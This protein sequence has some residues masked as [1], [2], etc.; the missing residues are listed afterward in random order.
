MAGYDE[1]LGQS[2]DEVAPLYGPQ[3]QTDRIRV[4]TVGRLDRPN[5]EDNPAAIPHLL[6]CAKVQ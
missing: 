2:A 3:A 5:R 4:P 1:A 6:G